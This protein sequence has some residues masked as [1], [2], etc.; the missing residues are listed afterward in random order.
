MVHAN[1]SDDKPVALTVVPVT[2]PAVLK[3]LPQ[4]V[5]WRYTWDP[6]DEEWKKV[7]F[8][9]RTGRKASSTNAKMWATFDVAF[10]AYL[11]G[12][13]DGIGL[14][15]LPQDNL[16]GI[17]LDKCRDSTTGVLTPEAAAI[18]AEM[19]SYTEA[20]PSGRGVRAYVRG[21][22]PGTKCR[23]GW[24]ELYDGTKA[25][26][27]PGGRYLTV[28]GHMLEN[29]P[30]DIW[31]RQEQVDALYK[32]IFGK[33][34]PHANNGHVEAKP[35]GALHVKATMSR[36]DGEWTD[37][38]FVRFVL[39]GH[40]EKLTSLWN[41]DIS[42]YP[43]HSEGDAA[44]LEKICYWLGSIN[45]PQATGLFRLSNLYRPKW[46]RE[47]Y[48]RH[49]FDL[50]IK[51]MTR[52]RELKAGGG[53]DGRPAR[54][55]ATAKQAEPEP[56]A[57]PIPF[58]RVADMPAFPTRALPPWLASWVLAEAEATQTPPDLAGCLALA[59]AGAAIARKARVNVRDG[60][61]EP[62]NIFTAVSL[63]PGERKSA[64]FSDAMAPVVE[65]EQAEREKMAPIIA[66]LTSERRIMEAKLKAAEQK[67]AKVDRGADAD[68]LR[69][70][71]KRLAKELAEYHIPDEPQLFCDDVTPEKLT[72]L[73]VRQGGRM[74]LASAEGTVF[75]IA[76]G[77]YSEGAN[78]DVFLKGH[79]GDPLRTGR[80]GRE[81]AI[82][83][84]VCD[85]GY[86]RSVGAAW[87]RDVQ[88]FEVNPALEL[89]HEKG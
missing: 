69:Q 77:R 3:G 17:D 61:Y 84:C 36:P 21:K 47:N 71:A 11:K 22:K 9:A 42:G 63:P 73:I 27:D 82:C 87:R 59:I 2:I 12:G 68:R 56:W 33:D 55:Q 34:V 75:E 65:H 58:G 8:S 76:K 37:E 81:S 1:T 45:E 44:L 28:T 60:W 35:K 57:K 5:V 74:L 23:K 40:D 26:G 20:S 39:E 24:I 16:V 41:G 62:A 32:K 7:P 43:S 13:W 15:H 14:I 38:D 67:A 50:L 48:R 46:E 64:V 53:G 83:K 19:V 80:V 89:D 52:F 25:D 30:S 51:R 88:V 78:F 72:Q 66:E 18:V 29:A 6:K 85:H 10:A 86:M 70:E 4:W 79:A 54:G 49:T 31:E